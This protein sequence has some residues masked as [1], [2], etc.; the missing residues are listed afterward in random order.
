MTISR[1]TVLGLLG[2][3]FGVLSNTVRRALA[4]A[5]QE[6]GGK[7]VRITY[8]QRMEGEWRL[9][10]EYTVAT[11]AMLA[12][13]GHNHR[14]LTKGRELTEHGSQ[15]EVVREWFRKNSPVAPPKPGRI[16]RVKKD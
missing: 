4:S 5:S 15:Y 9:D 8:V 2:L 10:A 3:A 11:N 14:T 16:E 1:R 12:G 6:K 13:G 7:G